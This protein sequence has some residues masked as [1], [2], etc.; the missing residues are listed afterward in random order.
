MTAGRILDL[1][2]GRIKETEANS[3]KYFDCFDVDI[4]SYQK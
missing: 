2:R 4:F 1:I 3:L